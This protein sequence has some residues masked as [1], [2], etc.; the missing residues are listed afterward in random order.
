MGGA[1][2]WPAASPETGEPPSPG[3][4]VLHGRPLR[5]G[6]VLQQTPQLSDDT[7]RLTAATLQLPKCPPPLNFRRIPGSYR[8][9]A[10]HLVYAMLSGVRPAGEQRRTVGTIRT[11]FTELQRFLIWLDSC[12][13]S[14]GTPP[15]L[16]AVTPDDIREYHRHLAA[17]L[18]RQERRAFAV[19]AVGYF[20]RYRHC[21]P[22]AE[23]LSFDPRPFS[24]WQRHRG[25]AENAT[26][27]I[28]EPVHGPLLGWSMRF[29]TDFAGDIL[30]ACR[31]WHDYRHRWPV[32][33][34]NVLA[35]MS[36]SYWPSASPD[37]SRSRAATA[38]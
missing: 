3:V 4:Y 11:V 25:R 38:A 9:A 15:A 17:T 33:R 20:W 29:T 1:V 37:S 10:K 18:P 31:Q 14:A 23:R 7:W 30:A 28:P 19:T 13:S 36:G 32:T 5:P 2:T 24:E 34:R 16:A 27:R 22:A 8:P 35:P 26:A 6:V 12:Q 21:P